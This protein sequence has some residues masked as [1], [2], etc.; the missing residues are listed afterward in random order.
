MPG[1]NTTLMIHN[2]AQHLTFFAKK[3]VIG[4]H[5]VKQWVIRYQSEQ[6]RGSLGIGPIKKGGFI[7]R[8]MTRSHKLEC[9]PPSR[10]SNLFPDL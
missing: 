1:V 9:P 2:L 10:G 3:G 7:D 5:M 6:K 4:Y 8:H